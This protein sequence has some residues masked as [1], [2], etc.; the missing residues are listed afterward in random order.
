MSEDNSDWPY[1][2]WGSQA[3]PRLRIA[4]LLKDQGWDDDV[5]FEYGTEDEDLESYDF[6]DDRGFRDRCECRL[7]HL[8]DAAEDLVQFLQDDEARFPRS[9]SSIDSFASLGGWAHGSWSMY[10]DVPSSVAFTSIGGG[11]IHLFGC[12]KKGH[13]C[14]VQMW[15]DGTVRI[16]AEKPEPPAYRK[17]QFVEVSDEVDEN[18]DVELEKA[19]EVRDEEL[20]DRRTYKELDE[21]PETS[22]P[23]EDGDRVAEWIEALA[24]EGEIDEFI[25]SGFEPE[26]IHQF[27]RLMPR[28]EVIEWI[29]LFKDQSEVALEFLKI[30]LGEVSLRSDFESLQFDEVRTELARSIREAI[31]GV[32]DAH[33]DQL[34]VFDKKPENSSD[35]FDEDD[36][37]YDPEDDPYL[38]D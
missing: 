29:L 25:S 37:P 21:T 36:F 12:S 8:F 1:S 11:S 2:D 22:E 26:Q 10:V 18:D 6:D 35:E 30:G 14:V 4:D 24:P 9:E 17:P 27:A 23:E 16:K 20:Y 33:K 7:I 34:R 3:E 31:S 13:S 38:D 19:R 5:N 32:L 15:S 28:S